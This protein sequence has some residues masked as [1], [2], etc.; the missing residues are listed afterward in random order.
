MS[1]NTVKFDGIGARHVTV[2]KGGTITLGTH[3]GKACYVHTDGTLYVGEAD[4]PLFGVIKAIAT[5]QITVQDQGY[6]EVPYTG[7]APT[8]GSYNKLECGAS[9]AVQVDATNGVPMMVMSV[10]TD[11]STCV[12]KLP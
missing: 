6:V 2:T 4:K 11:D 12:I 5:S 10:D 7:S 8:V 9:G 1:W 3:E